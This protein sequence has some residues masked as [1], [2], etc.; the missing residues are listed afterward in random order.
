[1]LTCAIEVI[2]LVFVINNL[3]RVRLKDKI[4]IN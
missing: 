3:D 1:M 4:A 2:K